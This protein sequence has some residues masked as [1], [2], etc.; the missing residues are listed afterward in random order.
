[1][2]QP[3]KVARTVGKQ[4]GRWAEL[5]QPPNVEH[6]DAVKVDQARHVVRNHND[7]MAGKLGAYDS[8]HLGFCLDIDAGGDT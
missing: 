5:D 4:L 6:G 1:M 7:G 8:L 3:C 2:M